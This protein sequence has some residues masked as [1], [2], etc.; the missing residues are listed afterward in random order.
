MRT[1]VR[2][3]PLDEYGNECQGDAPADD[4]GDAVRKTEADFI[5]QKICDTDCRQEYSGNRGVPVDS[6]ASSEEYGN[7]PQGEACNTLVEPAEVAPDGVETELSHDE[8]DG[9][10]RD[11]DGQAGSY[12]LLGDMQGIRNHEPG[13]AQGCVARGYG[14]DDDA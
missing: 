7:T 5:R 3:D 9:Q 6:A 2:G 13:A 14:K 8:A 10:Q 1:A 4:H 12:A 11:G